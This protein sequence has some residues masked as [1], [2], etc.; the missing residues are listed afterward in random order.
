LHTK[1]L[2]FE[3]EIAEHT[4]QMAESDASGLAIHNMSIEQPHDE[5]WLKLDES[6]FLKRCTKVPVSRKSTFDNFQISS[7]PTVELAGL[8]FHS[9][10]FRTHFLKQAVSRLNAPSRTPQT[11]V[12]LTDAMFRTGR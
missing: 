7:Q 6:T 11:L 4:F 12:T 3:A 9:A 10:Y 1:P 2:V 5:H 8:G